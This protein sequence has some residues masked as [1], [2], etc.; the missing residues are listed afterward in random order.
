MV[1]PNSFYLNSNTNT[2]NTF[3]SPSSSGPFTNTWSPQ[4]AIKDKFQDVRSNLESAGAAAGVSAFLQ[5]D[6]SIKPL[7]KLVCLILVLVC[8][9]N[10][11]TTRH[12]ASTILLVT[13]K[14][15]KDSLIT[16]LSGPCTPEYQAIELHYGGRE[17]ANRSRSQCP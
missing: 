9:V 15:L 8:L 1:L 16:V 14:S 10:W 3:S 7:L 2:L 4:N 5:K 11:L 12:E 6:P 17:Y 13:T